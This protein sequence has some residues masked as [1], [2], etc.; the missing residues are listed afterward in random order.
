MVMTNLKLLTK[1]DLIAFEKDIE[2]EWLSGKI[3]APV[4]LS[5]AKEE[6][7][8]SY[9]D[10]LIDIFRK[11][12]PQDWIFSTHR[13][14]YHALLKGV[15]PELVKAEILACRS[16]S[17]NFKD[18]KFFTSSIVAGS[19]PIALGIALGIQRNGSNEKVWCFLGDMSS[20]TG[21]FAECLRYAQ[22]YDL[23]IT[24]IIEDNS[25][26]VNSPTKELWGD[27][28]FKCED[29][30]IRCQYERIYP[31]QGVGKWILF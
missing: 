11:V 29:K 13:S 16:M 21:I 27:I 25:F 2:Q 23:P 5:G 10:A 20:G 15:P 24:F 22:F 31:H 8:F 26:S 18:Y 6:P 14:H 3:K 1:E 19:V 30:I 12:R 9:E 4:H 28:T 7:S 17:L